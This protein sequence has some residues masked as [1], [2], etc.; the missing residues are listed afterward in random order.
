MIHII[1]LA[2]LGKGLSGGDRIF[3]EFAR[4]WSKKINVCIFVWE[5]GLAMCRR[6]KLQGPK[7]QIR[8]IR[9]GKFSN[10]G[11]IFTYFYRIFLGLKL[12]FTLNLRD[13]DYLYSASEFWMDLLP[14]FILKLRYPKIKWVAAWYQTAPNPLRGFT[15][16]KRKDVYRFR[17]FFYWFI[18]KTVKPLISNFTDFILVNNDLEKKQF[19]QN[20]KIKLIT[21]LGAVKT[22]EVVKFQRIHGVPKN[23]KYLAVF[24]G[25]FHPQKG[26]LELM[27]I[28]KLVTDK[29][30]DAKLAVIGD[31]PLMKDVK[32]KIREL[33]LEKNVILFGYLYDGDKK[34]SIFNRSKIVVH[35]SF[36]DSGGMA[37]AE[38][39]VFGL[40]AI[41]FNLKSYISYYP[42]I[43]I[44][45]PVGDFETFA[46]KILELDG[47]EMLRNILGQRIKQIIMTQFSWE[48][49]AA[50][51]LSTLT[52]NNLR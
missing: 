39:M 34:Y 52:E 20:K 32:N 49:R 33:G 43:M 25:R 41:G 50:G 19:L 30:P 35:P 15:E 10:L 7:L 21:V 16:G 18:Q 24:Q 14:V 29:L 36:Y 8:L 27:E 31:G 5:E 44:K 28:W 40:P 9:V 17:A 26:I 22:E 47:D 51:V 38:A 48:R 3:I 23:K 37:A 4:N 13:G 42:K 2:A 45:V 11:F 1:A 12:A 46:K 6:E